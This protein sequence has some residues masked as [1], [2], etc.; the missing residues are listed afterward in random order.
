MTIDAYAKINL[1]LDVVGRRED[2]YH[3]VRMVMQTVALCDTLTLAVQDSGGDIQLEI[4][5]EHPRIDASLLPT[6]DRNLCVRAAKVLLKDA[7]TERG[8]DI[9]LTKRIPFEAGLAG[10][11]T[12][13]AA[14]LV[15]LNKL[16]NL[17]YTNEQL[18]A[19]GVRL[20][21]DIPYCIYGGTMLAEGIGEVLTPVEPFLPP[22]PVVLVKPDF[23]IATGAIYTALDERK[24]LTHPP[25]DALA[26]S[27]REQDKKGVAAHL[28]NVLEDV[29]VPDNPL[30]SEIKDRLNS[31]DALASRMTGSGPTVF[32][33]FADDEAANSAARR[34]GQLYP[35]YFICATRTIQPE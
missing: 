15:G 2:G 8:I 13:A 34:L 22:M 7:N 31:C 9:S 27:I 16:L 24:H 20:G 28:G 35:D 18:A 5:S 11:S 4:A 23:G 1:G 3:E 17:H 12:D 14:V 30:I 19:I 10:G 33:L 21:A 6:D 26:A 29:S 32:G 25:I